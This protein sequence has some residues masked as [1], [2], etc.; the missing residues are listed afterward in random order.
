MG[1]VRIRFVQT[2]CNRFDVCYNIRPAKNDLEI[3]IPLQLALS[4]GHTCLT[5]PPIPARQLHRALFVQVLVHVEAVPQQMRL[6]SPALS[7]ALKFSLVEVILQDRH[8]IG[9]RAFV[10]DNAGALA[11]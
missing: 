10:D 1:R 8:V 5:A 11:R 9:M 2:I 6:M 3:Y 4:T 7:Q